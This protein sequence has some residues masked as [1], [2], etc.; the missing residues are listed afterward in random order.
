MRYCRSIA[1]S[2]LSS[3]FFDFLRDVVGFRE[4]ALRVRDKAAKDNSGTLPI[5]LVV[6][7]SVNEG[8]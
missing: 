4:K 8:R 5:D 1:C 3:S 2:D 7:R 6:P